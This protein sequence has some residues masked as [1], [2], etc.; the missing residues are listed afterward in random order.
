MCYHGDVYVSPG[1]TVCVTVAA[2][3]THPVGDSQPSNVIK[4]TCPHKPM[5]PLI[6]QQPSYKQG[7]VLIA[8]EK[9][10]G[11]E[12]AAHGED[13]V[14]YRWGQKSCCS[15]LC[16]IVECRI[17]IFYSV[18]NGLV[19]FYLEHK[20]NKQADICMHVCS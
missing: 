14:F 3:T 6:T 17:F 19:N 7:S 16:K 9:P 4:V 11:S 20:K 2:V 15:A 18:L 12:H 10:P 5:V 8:W 13:I 1:R